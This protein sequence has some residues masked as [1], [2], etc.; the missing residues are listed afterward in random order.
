MFCKNQEAYL[1][2]VNMIIR[3]H[4]FQVADLYQYD[5]TAILILKKMQLSIL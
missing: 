5:H 3:F 2:N 4:S 1:P